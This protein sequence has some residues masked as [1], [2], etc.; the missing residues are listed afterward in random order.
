MRTIHEDE[1]RELILK[2]VVSHYIESGTPVGSRVLSKHLPVEWSP[3]TIRNIMA[4]LEEQGLL[5]HPYKSAGRVPTDKGYRAYVDA[6]M[7]REN[8]THEEESAIRNAVKQLDEKLRRIS[9]GVDEVLFYTSR[10]LARLSNELGIM[11]SPRFNLSVF[12]KLDLIKITNGRI[13]IELTLKTG[14]VKTVV[15][16]AETR[17]SADYLVEIRQVLNERLSGL[18]VVEIQ[19][20]IQERLKDLPYRFEEGQKGFVRLLINASGLLFN[21]DGSQL[22][23]YAGANNIL[24]KPDFANREEV[25]TIIQMLEEKDDF[26]K[27]LT[28]RTGGGGVDVKIGTE[29]GSGI[30]SF[31]IVTAGYRIGDVGGVVG[32]IGPKRMPY[33]RIIPLVE[34]TAQ[35]LNHA[36][37]NA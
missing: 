17:L 27:R 1:R 8:L 11:I 31:S 7:D 36:L 21:F 18:T 24:M 35:V 37:N 14:V 20:T 22:L 19:R 6:M 34:R 25:H 23:S 5:D 29:N 3:A 9:A 30:E 2:H 13:L 10:A 16:E 33:G 26:V 15:L 28:E 32:I 4:D 12:E